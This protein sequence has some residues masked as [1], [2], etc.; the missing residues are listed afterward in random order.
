[1]YGNEHGSQSQHQTFQAA[2]VFEA[3]CCLGRRSRSQS[4]CVATRKDILLQDIAR[5][6]LGGVKMAQRQEHRFS[7]GRL[8]FRVLDGTNHSVIG[9]LSTSGDPCDCCVGKFSQGTW[10]ENRSGSILPR[11]GSICSV[12]L[13]NFSDQQFPL[14]TS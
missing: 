3:I 6:P 10:I 12:K 11:I 1:M 2:L 13:A 14:L 7:R 8:R 9:S 4:F 5:S